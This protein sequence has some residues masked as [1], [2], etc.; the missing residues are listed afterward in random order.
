MTTIGLIGAGG[1]ARDHVAAYAR[2]PGVRVGWVAD[3]ASERARDLAA[4]AG[5]EWTADPEAVLA[6]PDVD[7]VDICT[8]S[9]SHAALTIAAAARG[10]HVHVEKPAALALADFDAMVAAA[11]E[12][13]VSL[14]VGQTAR[15]QPVHR[16]I[17]RALDEGAIGR[18]RYLHVLWYVGHVWAGG[19]RAW[20]LDPAR[21]GGHPLHNGIHALDLAVWLLGREPARVF[22]R[23]YRTFAPDMGIPDGFHITV[24]FDDGS[25]ALLDISYALRARGDALRRVLAV[26][27]AGSL[28]HSTEEDPALYSDAAPSPSPAYDDA[29]HAQLAHWVATLRGEAEPLVRNEQV[30]AAL[31]AALAAQRSLETGAAVAPGEVGDA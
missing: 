30:R 6:A 15:F 10:K 24:K 19:W 20:Q 16:E 1:I 26:G 22:A 13:G 14:M 2:I 7:A 9:A 29:L 21:S 25:L 27:E 31:A 23:G 28:S 11:R 18:L 3:V 8:P 12:H 17:R 5:A 4:L